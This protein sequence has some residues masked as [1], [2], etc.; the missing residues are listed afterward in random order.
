MIALN[1]FHPG[2]LLLPDLR[3]AAWQAELPVNSRDRIGLT[4]RHPEVESSKEAGEQ[5]SAGPS[6]V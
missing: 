2:R 1:I 5:I 4:E 3:A 6:T